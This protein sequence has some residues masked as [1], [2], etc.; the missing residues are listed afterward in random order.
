M[1]FSIIVTLYNKENTIKRALESVY[2]QKFNNYECIIIDDGS[3]DASSNI[4]KEYI[5]DKSNYK[6]YKYSNSGVGES[7]N[8][9]IKKAKGEYIVFLD[10]D[11]TLK[12]DLLL[13]LSCVIERNPRIDLIR[14]NCNVK[15]FKNVSD[16]EK[17]NFNNKFDQILKPEEALLCWK[18]I[19]KRYAVVWEYCVK[20]EIYEMNNLKFPKGMYEDFATIPLVIA[21]SKKCIGIDY[22]GYNYIHE[23]NS[24][25]LMNG[26]VEEEKRIKGFI[27]A[28][29]FA[30]KQIEQIN[31]S[32][33]LKNILKKDFYLRIYLEKE[34]IE[35]KL[36]VR[37]EKNKKAY[38]VIKSYIKE[39]EMNFK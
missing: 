18:D 2:I 13:K 15:H 24:K 19:K 20:R 34:N 16:P 36:L 30:L 32:E 11:D 3:I 14:Y 35:R 10:A 9:G 29:E 1:M 22:R 4:V 21:L 5:E 37:G 25:S 33:E 8:R 39:N 12:E 31:I 23:K 7:R 26:E 27:K 38:N 6:C 17:L 28:F